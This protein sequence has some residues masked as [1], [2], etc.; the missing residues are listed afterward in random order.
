MGQLALWMKELRMAVLLGG[1]G[2]HLLGGAVFSAAASR[3]F[4]FPW[5]T[6]MSLW[7]STISGPL[8]IFLS[9]AELWGKP[10]VPATLLATFVCFGLMSSY[11]LRP[12]CLTFGLLVLG[13]LVW[14]GFGLAITYGGK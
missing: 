4:A 7:L 2:F 14:V 1:L 6:P 11:F 10:N 5:H 12:R 8:A 9:P 13:Y 3:V